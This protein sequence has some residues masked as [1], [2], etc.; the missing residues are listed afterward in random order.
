M[1]NLNSKSAEILKQ[2]FSA[3]IYITAKKD[4]GIDSYYY[5]GVAGTELEKFNKE[6]DSGELNPNDYN[7]L[8]KGYG[9]PDADTIKEMAKKYGCQPDKAIS[10]KHSN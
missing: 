2:K 3:V 9:Q 10:I 7:V 5:I 6:L 4:S 8:R 1:I